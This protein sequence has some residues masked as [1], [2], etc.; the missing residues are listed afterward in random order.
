MRSLADGL[1]TVVGERGYRLSGGERQRLT[2]ARLLLA[3]PRVVILDEATAHLDSQSE[4]AVQEALVA[5]LAGRT[6]IVIAHR[7]STIRAADEILVVDDGRIVER[8]T[9]GHLLAAGGR[10]ADLHHTQFE[11]R[12]GGVGGLTRHAS[13]RPT[14]RRAAAA[15]PRWS[16]TTQG[17]R[18]MST[19]ATTMLDG[20]QDELREHGVAVVPGVLDPDAAAD[21]LDRL[22]AASGESVRRGIPAHIAGLDP[23]AANVRVFNLIDLDPLF[24]ELIAHPVAD[25][26]VSGLLGA[27]YIVSNF[28]ANIARPGSAS[29]VVHSDLAAVAPEPWLA[30]QTVNVDLVPH[31]RPSP[32]TAPRCTSRAATATRRWP[33]CRRT[34]WRTWCRSRPRPDRSS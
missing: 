26:V 23:N 24:A 10:Y 11:T 33:T 27:D 19:A 3:R 4:A 5:A 20:V 14:R 6:A 32:T 13:T 15:G 30:A 22:W 17:G 9:H 31:R 28:T 7:L 2:I 1:D 29:M 34:R 21:A 8:G 16:R 25:A 18:S 12:G